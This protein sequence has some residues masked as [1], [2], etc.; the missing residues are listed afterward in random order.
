MRRGQGRA[1]RQGE[2]KELQET[3]VRLGVELV[4]SHAFQ[5]LLK[6]RVPAA[7]PG[8]RQDE[9]VER[10]SRPEP[11]REHFGQRIL[12]KCLSLK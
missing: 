8:S 11:P 1:S 3:S 4:S 10:C 6:G 12:V 7:L 2:Y 5:A 9:A